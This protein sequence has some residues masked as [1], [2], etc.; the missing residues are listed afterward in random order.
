MSDKSIKKLSN[1]ESLKIM[2]LNPN[3]QKERAALVFSMA[4]DREEFE[5]QAME[6]VDN[7]VKTIT[8]KKEEVEKKEKEWSDF[9]NK[10]YD[11]ITWDNA[12]ILVEHRLSKKIKKKFKYEVTGFGLLSKDVIFV[13]FR[14]D[15][16]M[17]LTIHTSP[18]EVVKVLNINIEE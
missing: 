6:L 9:A 17:E 4:H 10:V 1:E 11:C 3:A 5:K 18:Q 14:L 8:Y 7:F 2:G 12:L 13:D 16:D 15:C